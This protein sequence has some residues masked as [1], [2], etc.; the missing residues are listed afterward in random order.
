MAPWWRW[1]DGIAPQDP[2]VAGVLWRPRCEVA[3][4]Q[5]GLAE[6]GGPEQLGRAAAQGHER[7][8]AEPGLAEAEH[9][10][11]ELDVEHG[12]DRL[13]QLDHAAAELDPVLGD[14]G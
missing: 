1:A 14:G 10:P 3:L 12:V 11:V 2:P 9:R 8:R 5:V 13:L 7:V 4:D 6:D